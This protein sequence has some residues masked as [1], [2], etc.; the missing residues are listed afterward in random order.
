MVCVCTLCQAQ[1]DVSSHRFILL[2]VALG[3]KP[4]YRR[5]TSEETEACSR[6]GTG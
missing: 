6:D 1:I 5:C 4:S 2:R 3:D